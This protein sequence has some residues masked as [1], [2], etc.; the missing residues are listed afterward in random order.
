MFPHTRPINYLDRAAT[1]AE[2]PSRRALVG[3]FAARTVRFRSVFIQGN[4]SAPN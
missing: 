1:R 2:D 4:R 3:A